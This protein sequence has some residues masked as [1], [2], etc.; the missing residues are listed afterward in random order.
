MAIKDLTIDQESIEEEI[1][2]Q[3]VSP[4]VRYDSRQKS[5]VLLPGESA[6]LNIPQK[7]ALYLLSLKGWKFIEEVKDVTTEAMPKEISEAIGENNSTV[8]NHLQNLRQRGVIYKTKNGAYT[9]LSHSVDK[10]K[11]L[12]EKGA[13]NGG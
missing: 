5:V 9:V 6:K 13:V 12:L 1:I 2:E 4:Y 10:I 3:V 11:D 8:R 7:I